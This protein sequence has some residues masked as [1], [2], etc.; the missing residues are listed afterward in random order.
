MVPAFNE[1]NDYGE[2]MAKIKKDYENLT[3]ES[4]DKQILEEKGYN[5]DIS[6]YLRR[7]LALVELERFIS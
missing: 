1:I 3:K 2:R 5:G 4:S 6:E 7:L